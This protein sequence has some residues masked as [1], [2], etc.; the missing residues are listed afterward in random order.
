MKNRR[1]T[2]HG[3]ARFARPINNFCPFAVCYSL[4]LFTGDTYNSGHLFI[5]DE[6]H[7]V[8][9]EAELTIA[10]CQLTKFGQK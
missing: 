7:K 1:C 5:L 4:A 10:V 8:S 3:G 9:A 6:Q 2:I